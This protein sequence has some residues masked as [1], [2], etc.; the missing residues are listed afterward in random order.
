M[1]STGVEVEQHLSLP[2]KMLDQP[3]FH[4]SLCRMTLFQVPITWQGQ[5]KVDVMAAA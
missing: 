3:V 4:E 5:M 2:A 1:G